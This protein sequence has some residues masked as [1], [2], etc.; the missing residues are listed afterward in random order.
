MAVELVG[1]QTLEKGGGLLF[2][3]SIQSG[4]LPRGFAALDDERRPAGAVLVC[5][6]APET[7][8]VGLEIEGEGR[9]RLR[10]AEPDEPVRPQIDA[11]PDATLEQA[12]HRAVG[13][14][15][16][17]HQIGVAKRIEARHLTVEQ[18]FHACRAR[19]LLQHA[20]QRVAAHAAEPMAC[21][22]DALAVIVHLDVVPVHEVVG[23]HPIGLR[24]RFGNASHGGIREDD[25]KPERVIRPIALDHANLVFGVGL[26]HQPGEVETARSAA[27]TDDAHHSS[28]ALTRRG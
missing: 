25:A 21:R 24:V 10:R 7:V 18:H 6:H 16:R 9:K 3:G 23:D 12:T 2:G 11:R 20:Q 13:A 15:G 1:E 19:L 14:V 8:L 28:I 4:R 22:R 27:H 5:V 26:L 17:D